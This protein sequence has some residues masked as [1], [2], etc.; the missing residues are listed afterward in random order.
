MS[1]ECER[2]SAILENDLKK[3]GF[4]GGLFTL[5][6]SCQKKYGMIVRETEKKCIFGCND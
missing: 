2:K 3:L 6:I 5:C 1:R 4:K